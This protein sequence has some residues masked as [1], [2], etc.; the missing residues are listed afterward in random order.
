MALATIMYLIH[1][2]TFHLLKKQKKNLQIAYSLIAL[3]YI[4]KNFRGRISRY[5][6]ISE[7]TMGC[8]KNRVIFL[9]ACSDEK[10][11]IE[12][13]GPGNEFALGQCAILLIHRPS[14]HC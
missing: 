12:V 11:M 14:S 3:N 8:F 2:Y 7:Y 4:F 10:K 1:Q 5:P 13:C 6:Q 9:S